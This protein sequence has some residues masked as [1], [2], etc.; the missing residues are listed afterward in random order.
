MKFSFVLSVTLLLLASACGKKVHLSK[1]P[2][3]EKSALQGNQIDEALKSFE[4]DFAEI[5]VPVNLRRLPVIVGE[6][7]NAGECHYDENGKGRAIVLNKNIF[8]EFAENDLAMKYFE[9][10]LLHEVG[11]CYFNRNHTK[12][13]RINFHGKQFMLP[14]EFYVSGF[15]SMRLILRDFSLPV[16]VMTVGGYQ[17]PKAYQKYYVAELANKA[18]VTQFEDLNSYYS[19][20]EELEGNTFFTNN[21][22]VPIK[23]GEVKILY[24]CVVADSLPLEKEEHE[25]ISFFEKEG[26]AYNKL[27]LI[28][29]KQESA[30]GVDMT[31]KLRKKGAIQASEAGYKY[32]LKANGELKCEADVTYDP[33]SPEFISSCS[34]KTKT[35]TLTRDHNDFMITFKI[36]QIGF[37]DVREVKVEAT[38]WKLKVSGFNKKPS[39]EMWKFRNEC[40]LEASAKFDGLENA[41]PTLK[42]LKNAI[43]AEPSPVQGNKT[44]RVLDVNSF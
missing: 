13:E 23:S 25:K 26:N 1:L 9:T 21:I 35:G 27:G 10:V 39:V 33:E 14:G 3:N 12:D 30:D 24:P 41:L 8:Y 18:H 37:S 40:I 31:L 43:P 44:G 6:I 36:P 42:A 11:H 22:E 19:E 5:G 2:K 16:S 34:F 15:G 17:I 4:E 28:Y 29:R 38:K 32:L 7:N 20:L